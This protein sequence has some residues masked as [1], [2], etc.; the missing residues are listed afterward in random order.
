MTAKK[1]LDKALSLLG[2]TDS[3]GNA[4]LVNRVR[5][6]AIDIIN[7]VYA[8]LF[9]A[10]NPEGD[11]ESVHQWEDKILLPE[12]ILNEV[13]PYG[14]ASFLASTENDAENMVVF[15]SLFNQKR[16]LLTH[17]ESVKNSIPTVG[18]YQ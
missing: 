6:R 12:R 11:F 18:D 3:N 9:Y 8:D 1:L 4:Q 10:L 5:S 14:V 13:A 17:T 7:Q 15:S 2:Y 16:A